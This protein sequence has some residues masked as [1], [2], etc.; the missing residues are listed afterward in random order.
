[1]WNLRNR[2]LV[3]ILFVAGLGL[4]IASFSSYY[5]AKN[6]FDEAIEADAMGSVKSLTNIMTLIFQS[7]MTDVEQIAMTLQAR[8]ILNHPNDPEKIPP[9]LEFLSALSKSKPYYQLAI[10]LD[11]TGIV[12]AS[13]AGSGVGD[14][15]GDRAYF[16]SAMQG[17]TVISDPIYS[18]TT[19]KSVI[20][21]CAPVRQDKEIIGCVYVSV[22]LQTLSDMY[23]KNIVL[24]E[25]VMPRCSRRSKAS[26][27]PRP[28]EKRIAMPPCVVRSAGI[29]PKREI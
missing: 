4:G 7:A 17:Q 24:G 29:H 23:V 6:A 26:S 25:R 20:I 14:S 3:P 28:T 11:K 22:D 9:F 12:L 10:I 2:L 15:R 13:T 27:L 19:Q 1:M 8:D 16:K 18:R 5:I 21:I